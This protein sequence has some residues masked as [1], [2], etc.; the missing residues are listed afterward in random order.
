MYESI[1]ST[2]KARENRLMKA[3]IKQNNIG[4]WIISTDTGSLGVYDYELSA[5]KMIKS[6]GYLPVYVL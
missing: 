5:L 1:D 3:Y 4:K 2:V 6:L